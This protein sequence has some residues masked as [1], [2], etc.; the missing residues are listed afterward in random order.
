MFIL[1]LLGIAM[2]NIRIACLLC[3]AKLVAEMENCFLLS[4]FG[5]RGNKFPKWKSV[6]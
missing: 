3:I 2:A 4:G 5:S 6:L 1:S